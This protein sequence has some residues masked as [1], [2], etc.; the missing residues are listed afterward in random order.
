MAGPDPYWQSGGLR[1]YHG[2][3]REI[4]PSLEAVESIITDPV[5]PDATAFPTIEDPGRLLGEALEAAPEA[6][7]LVVHLGVDTDPRFLEAVGRVRWPF[8]R[9]CWLRYARPSYKGR[10][11]NGSEVAYVFGEPPAANTGHTRML[12]PGESGTD[13]EKVCTDATRRLE[14]HP[15]PRRLSHVNWLVRN[16][17]GESVLDPFMGA[18]T[19]LLAAK[20]QG[21]R[22]IGI[23]MEEEYCEKAALRLGQL[24][25]PWK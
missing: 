2:D 13:G 21:V 11:L 4:L 8:F 5:W 16:F 24:M 23:E 14:W 18:G 25:I 3:C 9:V 22:G 6:D 15:C 10:L 17:G 19:T 12:I 7:R 20:E 1:I